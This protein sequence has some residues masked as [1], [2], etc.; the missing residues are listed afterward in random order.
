LVS[1]VHTRRSSEL[2]FL[3][4]LI[5]DLWKSLSWV[6]RLLAPC[7]L[8]AMIIGVILGNF[9][10]EGVNRAFNGSAQWNGVSIRDP[11]VVE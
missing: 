9:A 10:E 3:I 8:I 7:V 11:V 4:V 5:A 6:D 1:L 2:V